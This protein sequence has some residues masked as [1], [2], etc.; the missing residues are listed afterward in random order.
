MP[1]LLQEIGIWDKVGTAGRIN[2]ISFD[3]TN[4]SGQ[5]VKVGPW[6]TDQGGMNKVRKFAFIFVY[7]RSGI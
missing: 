6:G 3:Y 5:R 4:E 1:K 7:V 2:A